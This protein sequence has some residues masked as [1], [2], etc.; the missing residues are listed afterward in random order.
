MLT[1]LMI[2]NFRLFKELKIKGLS[3]VN[4][5]VGKNSVGKSCL[6][7]SLLIYANNANPLTLFEVVSSRDALWQDAGKNLESDEELV[8]LENPLRNLFFN[9]HFPDSSEALEIGP[10]DDPQNRIKIY[11]KSFQLKETEDGSLLRL[12][13]DYPQ[14][15]SQSKS[16]YNIKYGLELDDGVETTFLV[17][18]VDDRRR[19]LRNVNIKRK[20]QRCKNCYVPTNNISVSRVVELW[21]N[22]NLSDLEKE[23]IRC[24]RIVEPRVDRIAFIGES[25][26]SRYRTEVRIPVVRCSGV[27]ER[28]P[29]KSLG[30]GM[31]RLFHI[32]LA[33][34]NSASG[35]LIVDEIENGLHWSI[36]PKLW[37]L[38]FK[39]SAKLK[40]QVFA[41][42][43]SMDCVRA[44]YSVWKEFERKGSFY[45]LEKDES[46]G[47]F[48][49]QY[50]C[51]MLR[52][53]LNSNTE[54]R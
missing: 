40:V 8:N 38:I 16:L 50:D 15:S 37:E 42:T 46:C 39:L 12:P 31:N 27:N 26:D 6:L 4:L 33:L 54:M 52:A 23:V 34:V 10:L 36:Q 47:V 14:D 43:H 5:F 21:D 17:E 2:K 44:Y 18:L 24:L 13:I 9:Y 35:F 30:D 7:E 51:D 19:F 22:I 41:T 32:S 45:R 20:D 53:S 48:P 3:N 25:F 11:L 28:V 1:S 49:F 29:L